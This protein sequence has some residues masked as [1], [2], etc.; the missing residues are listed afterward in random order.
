MLTKI[1]LVFL[2]SVSLYVPASSSGCKLL[3]SFQS[4]ERV[5]SASFHCFCGGWTSGVPY[6]AAFA[7]VTQVLGFKN[8]WRR[9]SFYEQI[10][11]SFLNKIPKEKKW[12]FFLSFEVSVPPTYRSFI[13]ASVQ[14]PRSW[15]CCTS[16]SLFS[17]VGHRRPRT[18]LLLLKTWF[19]SDVWP[20]EL[21]IP[22][23]C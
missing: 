7:D 5:D 16:S 15:L 2:R 1:Q 22:L 3:M 12:I 23:R 10:G 4:S 21:Q 8:R 6:S 20:G 19:P 17:C 11:P 13:E 14:E 9:W 18:A